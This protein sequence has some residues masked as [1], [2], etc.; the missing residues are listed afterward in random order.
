MWI[1][2]TENCCQWQKYVDGNGY[3]RVTTL[4]VVKIKGNVNYLK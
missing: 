4:L 3:T 1:E 2:L